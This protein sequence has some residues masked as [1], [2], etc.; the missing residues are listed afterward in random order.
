MFPS[1]CSTSLSPA[2]S[3]RSLLSLERSSPLRGASSKF[4]IPACRLIV[5]LLTALPYQINILDISTLVDRPPIH[6]S[7]GVCS[8]RIFLRSDY[9]LRWN[10]STSQQACC[11]SGSLQTQ[12][13]LGIPDAGIVHG[14][15]DSIHYRFVVDAIHRWPSFYQFVHGG[16]I[17][18]ECQQIKSG[19]CEQSLR[20]QGWDGEARRAQSNARATDQSS[21]QFG[22]RHLCVSVFS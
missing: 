14:F 7:P 4:Q 20:N 3:S 10:S 12:D 19:E 9:H 8:E 21:T 18:T 6:L 1:K 5:V 16:K 22:S 17:T 2:C 11:C 13:S 15:G